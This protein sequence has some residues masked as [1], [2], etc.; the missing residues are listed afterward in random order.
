MKKEEVI[1]IARS[2]DLWQFP[3]ITNS[4]MLEAFA[5]E[6]ERRTLER[7]AAVCETVG[8][9]TGSM[10]LVGAGFATAVRALK[11]ST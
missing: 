7:A 2:V 5:N 3:H 9:Q 6:V 4:P 10:K 1:E 11:E 8:P